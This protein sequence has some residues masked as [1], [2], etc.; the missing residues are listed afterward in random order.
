MQWVVHL[1]ENGFEV[2]LN[3]IDNIVAHQTEHG[4]PAN[5]RGCHSAYVGDK[6]VEGHVPADLLRQFI[7]ENSDFDGIAV[8]GMPVGPP[9][10]EGREPSPY[11]VI[12]FN[13]D[14]STKH[15]AS[16]N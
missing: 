8:A 1:Q 16:R 12:L 11:D 3:E 2:E 13:K 9:G 5:A 14:G 10:M 4:V 15:Y 6:M 7:G